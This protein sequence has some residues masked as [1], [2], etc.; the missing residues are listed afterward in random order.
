MTINPTPESVYSRQVILDTPQV[1]VCGSSTPCN[2]GV[3]QILWPFVVLTCG[4]SPPS[5]E[6]AAAMLHGGMVQDNGA[7][8]MVA[9]VARAKHAGLAQ[10]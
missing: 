9:I 5:N 7:T 6:S 10:R 3:S 8:R 2:R 4:F 1:T